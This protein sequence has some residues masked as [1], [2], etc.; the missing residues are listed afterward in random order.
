M[1]NHGTNVEWIWKCILANHFLLKVGVHCK[2]ECLAESLFL[3]RNWTFYQPVHTEVCQMLPCPSESLPSYKFTVFSWK[4]VTSGISVPTTFGWNSV[5]NLSNFNKS[6][7]LTSVVAMLQILKAP[8]QKQNIEYSI[9]WVINHQHSA[10]PVHWF[11]EIWWLI[12]L[13]NL[14]QWAHNVNELIVLCSI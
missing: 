5:W 7:S 6:Q 11:G 8:L 13:Q 9:G 10:C 2:C 12:M 3:P 14:C 1:I 4:K